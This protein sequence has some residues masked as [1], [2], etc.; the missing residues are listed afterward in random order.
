MFDHASDRLTQILLGALFIHY[1][2]TYI[3]LLLSDDNIDI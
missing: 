2:D 3:L 1:I